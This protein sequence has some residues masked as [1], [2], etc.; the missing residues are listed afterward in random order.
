MPRFLQVWW[1]VVLIAGGIAWL[2]VI[3]APDIQEFDSWWLNHL[4]KP[5]HLLMYASLAMA[6][7]WSAAKRPVAVASFASFAI[8][9]SY[10]LALEGIQ[11][12]LPNRSFDVFDLFANAL[13]AIL[14][15][16]AFRQLY[17]NKVG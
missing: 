16:W 6:F 17:P 10:G 7:C 1:L 2:S 3:K 4:D 5:V 12:F 11:Y 13:G 14:G 15:M 9:F 8:V